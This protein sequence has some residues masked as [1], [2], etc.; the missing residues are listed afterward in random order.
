[1]VVIVAAFE[2]GPAIKNAN[3]APGDAPA[4]ISPAA[5]GT[6]ADAQT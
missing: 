5:I 4:W 6:E 1:M 2:A 3:T